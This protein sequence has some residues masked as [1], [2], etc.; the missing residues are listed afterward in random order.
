M[1]LHQEDDSGG[2]DDNSGSAG[3]S[4]RHQL[5]VACRRAISESMKQ[6]KGTSGAA[7]VAMRLNA[8]RKQLLDR[9]VFLSYLSPCCL[10]Q[11]Q[12]MEA[13]YDLRTTYTSIC[14]WEKNADVAMRLDAHLKQFSDRSVN[15][16]KQGFTSVSQ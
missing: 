5:D 12:F 1:T 11:H 3:A 10:E 4:E 7:D 8:H 13:N 9:S 2:H 16:Y 6:V 15:F 14:A